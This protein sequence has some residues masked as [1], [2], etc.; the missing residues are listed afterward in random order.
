MLLKSNK[1]RKSHSPR[2]CPSSCRAIV[3]ALGR[4]LFQNA[5]ELSRPGR[6][7]PSS[8]GTEFR[9]A[10]GQENQ[11]RHHHP[12]KS[13]MPYLV[14]TVGPEGVTATAVETKEEARVLASKKTMKVDFQEAS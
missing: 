10:E 11:D 13:G 6:G 5:G 14:V 7:W 2:M 12:P 8:T 3:F 4:T 9:H 1:K